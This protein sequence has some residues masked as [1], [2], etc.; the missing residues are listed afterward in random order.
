[1]GR[2]SPSQ[3]GSTV[4]PKPTPTKKTATTKAAGK[5]TAGAPVAP[6]RKPQE[7]TAVVRETKT[8]R[9]AR[10]AAEWEKAKTGAGPIGAGLLA[11]LPSLP[12]GDM[13][14]DRTWVSVIIGSTELII[15]YWVSQ[16]KP[17]RNPFP[18]PHQ[19]LRINLWK[20]SEILTWAQTEG[21]LA[22]LPEGLA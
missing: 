10:A 15:N 2:G 11:G 12:E 17:V 22:E 4:A 18:R 13:W 21:T 1:M 7:S 8:D 3:K 19:Y 14:L 5:K 20:L 16:G 6:T 9:Q